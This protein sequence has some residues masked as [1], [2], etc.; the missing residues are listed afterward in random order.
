V[1][2]NLA[3][4]ARKILT[5]GTDYLKTYLY[6]QNLKST[7][8]LWLWSLKDFTILGIAAL[9][10]VLILTQSGWLIPA[11]A[12]LLFAFLTVRL[13]DNTVLDFIRYAVKY[14]ITTQQYYEWRRKLIDNG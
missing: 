3:R 8:N 11:A 2:H 6:P 9:L 4:Y 1:Y 13:E 12:T 14:F 7:A 5:E 10:S